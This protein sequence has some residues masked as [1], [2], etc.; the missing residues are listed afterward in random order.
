MKSILTLAFLVMIYSEACNAQYKVNKTKYDRHTY[1][2]QSG[3][4]YNPSTMALASALI[5]G[6]GEI[7]EGEGKRGFPFLV[8][9]LSLT[10]TKYYVFFRN[11]PEMSYTAQ[12]VIRKSILF[13]QI[14]LRIWSAIDASRVA[15]VNNLAFRDKY[16]KD[17]SLQILP[18]CEAQNN[19]RIS[20]F[21]PVGITIFVSF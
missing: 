18:F 4:P 17:I 10:V 11:S 13:T 7:L 6:L 8:G 12:D 20:M 15:K 21:Y 19:H 14:G 3:D 2:Y 16:K 1:S 5:P 9:S